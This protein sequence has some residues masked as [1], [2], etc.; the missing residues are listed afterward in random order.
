MSFQIF[1][2][3][4][5]TYRTRIGQQIVFEAG[6]SPTIRGTDGAIRKQTVQN[7]LLELVKADRY[8]LCEQ[9]RSSTFNA[10]EHPTITKGML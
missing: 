1:V 10:S 2:L 4:I 6:P 3:V 5:L 9:H 7:V 8:T